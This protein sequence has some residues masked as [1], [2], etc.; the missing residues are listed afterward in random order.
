MKASEIRK[1]STDE[2][3]QKL[4]DSTE[5]LF[6]LRFQHTTNQLK[7][8]VRLGQIRRDIARFKTITVERRKSL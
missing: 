7:N 3:E 2:L 5:E 8:T 6:N 4:K 1:L